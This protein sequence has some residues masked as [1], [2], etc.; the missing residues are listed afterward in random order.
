LELSQ[1]LGAPR[2]ITYKISTKDNLL[3]LE[4]IW[5]GKD[6][7]RIQEE[8]LLRLHPV[9]RKENIRL[10][11]LG[12]Y[13]NPYDVVAS[14]NRSNSAIMFAKF[15]NENSS[16]KI[17]SK[18]CPLFSLGKGKIMK[19]DNVYEDIKKDGITFI[20]H[21]NIWGTNFPLWYSDNAYFKFEI[22]VDC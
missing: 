6:A 5:T 4:L 22:K 16:F 9:A 3:V 21:N 19:F 14:G 8:T 20:L 10:N 18:H 12:S 11:K 17:T 7:N 15:E 2:E 13:V 1:E